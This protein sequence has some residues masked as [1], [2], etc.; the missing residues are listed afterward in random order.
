MKRASVL[1][2]ALAVVSVVPRSSLA[3]GA[4]SS[5]RPRVTLRGLYDRVVEVTVQQSQNLKPT[6]RRMAISGGLMAIADRVAPAA[7]R[8]HPVQ[9]A[10]EAGVVLAMIFPEVAA[11]IGWRNGDVAQPRKG[12]FLA[13]AAAR[14]GVALST[15]LVLTN[16]AT[17]NLAGRLLGEPS[18]TLA[19]RFPDDFPSSGSH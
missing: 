5:K 13:R 16:H 8:P 6:L 14:A 1:A 9:A 4:G 3:A 18:K 12:G 7:A 15:G 2:I 10:V 11:R 17:S 19:E